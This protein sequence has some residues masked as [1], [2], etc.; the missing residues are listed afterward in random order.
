MSFLCVASAASGQS[1]DTELFVGEIS[2]SGAT[3][4]FGAWKNVTQRAGYD[5]QPSFT[6][7]SRSI[8]YTVQSDG[9]TDIYR[10]DLATGSNERVT[11]T[12][13]SEYSAAV[14]PGGDRFSA[15][16]VE[17][18]STQRLWSFRMDGSAPELVLSDVAPVGYQAWLDERTLALFVLGRPS[19]LQ[20]ADSRTGESQIRAHDI[21]RSLHRV[22]GR[23]AVSFIHRDGGVATIRSMDPHNGTA[24]DLAPP[25]AGSQ[26]YAWTPDGVLIM[27]AGSTLYAF[28]PLTDSVWRE[29]ADLSDAGVQD[30]TRLAVSPDGRHIAVVATER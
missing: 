22:P 8:L 27:G 26:D 19:T 20:I 12:A 2:G 3:V 24:T 5:N 7:D 11:S 30:I 16:R 28:D 10:H 18:D 6:P 25:I 14:M 29:V 9:Q 21:G 13:E 17:A 23:H 15:I 1:P 4:S